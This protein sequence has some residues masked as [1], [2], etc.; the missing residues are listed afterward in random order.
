MTPIEG[1]VLHGL[2][3]F[4]LRLGHLKVLCSVAAEFHGSAQRVERE[5]ARALL[6]PCEIPRELEQDIAA[7][8]LKKKLCRVEGERNGD[9]EA[10]PRVR[11]PDLV[12]RGVPGSLS[13]GANEGAAPRIWW[14]D[15]CLAAP[16]IRSRVG[17]V[18]AD[19][20]SGSKTGL[21]HL[22]DWTEKLDLVGAGGSPSPIGSIL[23]RLG[24]RSPTDTAANPYLLGHEVMALAHVIIG[25]DFDVFSRLLEQVN[26]RV[27][28]IRKADAAQCYADAVEQLVRD[29]DIQKGLS[30]GRQRTVYALHKDLARAGK[31]GTVGLGDTSTAWHRTASR[32]ET[33]VDLG[34]LE[35]GAN[36]PDELYEYVY[37]PTARLHR[38]LATLRQVANARE[39]LERF[40]VP[41]LCDSEV[42]DS[43]PLS[44]LIAHVVRIV[45]AVGRPTAPLPIDAVALGVCWMRA[46]EGRPVSLAAARRAIEDLA[47][48]DA[49]AARLAR[50]HYSDRAA[51]VSFDLRE[52]RART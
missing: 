47:R 27:P 18:T 50:G 52:L 49:G 42:A 14:Q 39:W 9:R 8:L 25:R 44:D 37:Y 30:A 16:G 7:Y 40:L 5:T 22:F 15:L 26:Q 11:Y 38:A 6:R 23:A 1:R 36:G 41:V 10:A 19:A 46:D 20:K 45:A 43:I 33:Y 4:M 32:M 12:V 24:E 3:E 31:R 17:A 34:L 21:S 48:T 28:P 35:K 2:D 13:I 51:Y 29:C